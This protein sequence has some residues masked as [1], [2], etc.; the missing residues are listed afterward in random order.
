MSFFLIGAAG[1]PIVFG[2]L[3]LTSRKAITD[4]AKI[5]LI[6]STPLVFNFNSCGLYPTDEILTLSPAW[7]SA[8]SISTLPLFSVR[9]YLVPLIAMVARAMV[10]VVA[11]S[12][13]VICQAVSAAFTCGNADAEQIDNITIN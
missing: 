6:G 12:A 9:Q 7:I 11:L 10:L 13:T 8:L 3:M 4:G 1:A 5:M 2:C